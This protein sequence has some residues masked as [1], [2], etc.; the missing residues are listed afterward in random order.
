L[1]SNDIHLARELLATKNKVEQIV[2]TQ[3][4]KHRKPVVIRLSELS[5]PSLKEA[6]EQQVIL[7]KPSPRAPLKSTH[8]VLGGKAIPFIGAAEGICL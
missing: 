6:G 5:G 4:K 7:E 8:S 1:R 3:F 2:V